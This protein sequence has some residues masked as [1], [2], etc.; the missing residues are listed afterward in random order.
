M[1]WSIMPLLIYCALLSALFLAVQPMP[2]TE[3]TSQASIFTTQQVA[4][5]SFVANGTKH[6]AAAYAKYG[7]HGTYS[8]SQSTISGPNATSDEVVAQPA[9]FDSEYVVPI[10]INGQELRVNLDTGS[11]DLW[12]WSTGLPAS[13]Q[14]GHT[15]YNL[16]N[17]DGTLSI[18]PKKGYSWR[19]SYGDGT[20]ASGVVGTASVNIGGGTVT[21][22]SVE[23]ATSISST[24]VSD[25][26]IDGIAGFG[27]SKT[28][29]VRP[30]RQLGFFDKL[31]IQLSLPIFTADLKHNAPGSYDF[32]FINSSKYTGDSIYY[33]NVTASSGFWMF[34][35]SGYAVGSGAAILPHGGLYP[36]IVDTGTSL[37]LMQQDMVEAYYAQVAS[38]TFDST[39]GGYVFPC[40]SALPD[41]TIEVGSYSA[42]IGSEYM[43]YVMYDAIC[44]FVLAL[45]IALLWGGSLADKSVLL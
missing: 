1:N 11:A 22:Q 16:T 39:Q 38:A 13:E 36:T 21:S 20:G 29:T 25:T 8:A 9:P 28:N 43:V 44:K 15:C 2:T 12:V 33:T 26:K 37:L 10:G 3:K 41:L 40:D 35:A 17:P 31:K 18:T 4:N 45:P 6:I 30:I 34:A 7:N 14:A 24:L 42:V 19:I 32:G 23:L 27:F 5:P